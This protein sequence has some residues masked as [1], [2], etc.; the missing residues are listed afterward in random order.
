[1]A[2]R[3]HDVLHHRGSRVRRTRCAAALT[4]ALALAGCSTADGVAPAAADPRAEST[5]QPASSAGG[6]CIML[7]Y[8]VVQQLLGVR[9]DIAASD[10]ADNTSTCVLQSQTA[11]H[12]DLVLSVVERTDATGA[13]FLAQMKPET[14]T[15]LPHL[16]KAAY[17]QVTPGGHGAG[18]AVELG[19]L[20][21]DAQI[22]TL[23]FTFAP[24]GTAKQADD[25]VGRLVKLARAVDGGDL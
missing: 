21:G 15:P 17:H 6:A 16:G 20:T 1:V 18:P 12:P 2:V 19:I 22:M 3:R 9:F 23:R 5:R 4:A 24:G 13:E 11:S 14:A 10:Q 7:D 25:M 8:A